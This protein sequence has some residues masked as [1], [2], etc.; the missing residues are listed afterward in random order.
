MTRTGALGTERFTWTWTCPRRVATWT[1]STTA[2]HCRRCPHTSEQIID[3][4]RIN[5]RSFVSAVL[6][7][8]VEALT[9]CPS[10]R[11][12]VATARFSTDNR[13]TATRVDLVW[14]WREESAIGNR[15]RSIYSTYGFGY[16]QSSIFG[17]R[18]FFGCH[19]NCSSFLWGNRSGRRRIETCVI[20]VIR[21]IAIGY[22]LWF[23][24]L[25]DHFATRWWRTFLS[26]Q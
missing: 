21:L 26:C 23:V 10:P 25:S 11:T 2:T 17:I 13:W 24:I 3:C 18:R 14:L 4:R 8:G 5:E 9:W 12:I 19:R 6:R 15:S 7:V 1:E 20:G 16:E 22:R